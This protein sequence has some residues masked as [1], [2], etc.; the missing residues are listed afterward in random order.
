MSETLPRGV[1]NFNPGNID[2]DG[3]QWDGLAADQSSDPRFCVF[4][5]AV[6]GIRAL[7]KILISYQETDGLKTVRT[8]INRWAPPSEN[9]STAYVDFVAGRMLISPDTVFDI[10]DWN[11]CAMM[12]EAIIAQENANY[13]YPTATITEAM[14]LAGVNPP[15]PPQAVAGEDGST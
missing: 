6:Y 2:R 5:S 9:D 8:M 3:T 15:P 7:I 4:T 10:M 14:Q 1:R 11:L 13:A 12:T